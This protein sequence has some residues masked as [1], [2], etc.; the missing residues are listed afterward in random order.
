MMT[1]AAVVVPAVQAQDANPVVA[2]AKEI[3]ARQSIYMVKAAEEM[4]ADK[5]GY[6]PTPE[7][8]TFGKVVAHVVQANNGV[9]G[10]LSGT[11]APAGAPVTETSSK[12]ALV[13]ALKASFDFCGPAMDNLKDAQLGEPVTFFGGV[14]KPKARALVEIVADLEDHYSQMASYLRL[15]GMLPPS[16]APRK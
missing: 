3:Y 15:N 13:A 4:P 5:Y 9:C 12:E 14:K 2:S 7:Q 10:M 6:R 1:M 8:W 16:A 11:K